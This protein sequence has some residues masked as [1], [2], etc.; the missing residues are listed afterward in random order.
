VTRPAWVLFVA[1]VVAAAAASLAPA[2]VLAQA[3]D[4]RS[5]Q[6]LLVVYSPGWDA[7]RG[8]LRRFERKAPGAAFQPVGE[9]LAVA[10]GR[11]GLAWRSDAGAP[12]PLSPGPT[13]REGDGRSPAGLLALGAM[14]GYEKNPPKGVHIAYK[15]ADLRMRCVDDAQSPHYGRIVAAPPEGTPP[16]WRS[17]ELLRMPTDHYKYLVVIDYNMKQP[18][19]GAGSCIFLHVAPAPPGTT[20]PTAGCTSLIESE[21]LALLRWIDPQRTPLLLQLP[22]DVL[23][24]TAKSFALDAALAQAPALFQ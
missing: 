9:P 23:L 8:L 14:W 11:A 15:Q 1:C 5:A 19:P 21:L 16:P 22:R 10:L 12:P 18:R 7:P 3:L 20:G 4:I 13:K 2:P 6:Q 24:T 17:A